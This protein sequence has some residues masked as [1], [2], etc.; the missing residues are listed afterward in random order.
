MKITLKPIGNIDLP[1]L[2]DLQKILGRSFGCPVNVAM[3]LDIPDHAHKKGRGQ[4]LASIILSS[5]KASVAEPEERIL[6][7][8]DIDLYAK[9]LNF[10]FGQADPESG[11]A[12]ISL[13]RLRQEL[14]PDQALFLSRAAKEAIH[15]L[16]HTFGLGHCSRSKCIMHFSDSLSDTDIKEMAFCS[17][18]Q[19]KLIQ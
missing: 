8:A 7:I 4:Y 11:V 6:G 12:V 14:P 15:E 2:A 19:P 5:L 16:G 10:V 9:G 1:I 3:K 13:C 18:C 17:Q